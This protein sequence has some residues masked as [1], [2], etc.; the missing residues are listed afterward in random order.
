MKQKI[1][2]VINTLNEEQN[3][4]YALRSVRSWVD[5]IVV[6]DM[7]SDDRTVEI[8]KQYG[9]KVYQ[10]ERILAFDAARK[11]AIEQAT[12]SWILVLDAD[13]E[14]TAALSIAIRE[15]IACNNYDVINLPRANL[16]LSGFAPHESG[17]PEYHPRL[18]RKPNIN[19]NDYTAKIH[20]F[21]DFIQGSRYITIKGS[22]PELCM[23]HFTNPTVTFF[24]DKINGYTTIEANQRY[25]NPTNLLLIY[26]VAIK[27]LKAFV[28]HYIKRRGFLDGWR[29]FWLSIIFVIYEFLVASKIWEKKLY[30]GSLPTVDQARETMRNLVSYTNTSDESNKGMSD[31]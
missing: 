15:I 19:L 1:S 18:F 10:H 27:T 3:L 14:I 21:F 22:Y 16:A 25:A 5:E 17:Y 2:V 8:A 7:Y 26:L 12:N 29:G 13:E 30:N 9:A 6:V 4:P 20:T 24:I 31:L 28:V 23:L 11:F